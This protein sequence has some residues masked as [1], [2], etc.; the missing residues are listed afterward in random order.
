MS[1]RNDQESTSW[2]MSNKRIIVTI[3]IIICGIVSFIADF[4]VEFSKLYDWSSQENKI[5]PTIVTTLPFILNINASNKSISTNVS[6]KFSKVLIIVIDSRFE[7]EPLKEMVFNQTLIKAIIG[8]PGKNYFLYAFI[9]NYLYTLKYQY[10][11]K[12]ITMGYNNCTNRYD[13]RKP[14]KKRRLVW[15]K[16]DI[17]QYYLKNTNYEWIIYFDADVHFTNFFMSF[18]DFILSQKA[19]YHYGYTSLIANAEWE[20][21]KCHEHIYHLIESYGKGFTDKNESIPFIFNTTEFNSKRIISL[22]NCTESINGGTLFFRNNNISINLLNDWSKSILYTPEHFL[23]TSWLEQSTFNCW[24]Y[25]KYSKYIISKY[26]NRQFHS[27]Y[28]SNNIWNKY[29]LHFSGGRSR[30]LFK[31]YLYDLINDK[32][33]S[34]FFTKYKI[35]INSASSDDIIKNII[36]HIFDKRLTNEIKVKNIQYYNMFWVDNSFD[37]I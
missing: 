5:A 7:F 36:K 2:C 37:F 12:M 28:Y 3:G 31:R 27:N 22:P 4:D 23:W 19:D 24:I 33:N 29:T 1:P 8:D 13:T 18:N 10:S 32:N 26:M 34:Q 30:N 21:N 6:Q 15:C 11:M 9:I 20:F 14:L 25:Q 35:N 17:I 16:M